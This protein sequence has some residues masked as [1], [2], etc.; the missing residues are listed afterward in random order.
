M[1]ANGNVQGGIQN[2]VALQQT[3]GV[4]NALSIFFSQPAD[5]VA[6]WKIWVRAR[7]SQGMVTVGA[8]ETT[9]PGTSGEP[10]SRMVAVCNCPGATGWAITAFTA[11]AKEQAFV[12]LNSSTDSGGLP[13]GITTVKN[14]NRNANG[15]RRPVTALAIGAAPLNVSGAGSQLWDAAGSIRDATLLAL[16][17]VQFF[18]QPI[19]PVLGDVP[20]AGLPI[21][22]VPATNQIVG[23]GNWVLP[24]GPSGRSIVN[25]LWV[26]VSSTPN[27][28]TPIVG[29]LATSLYANIST[30]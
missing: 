24:L 21:G 9:A 5:S 20:F 18:D 1:S 2:D 4:G 25:Q 30:V 11:G 17:F 3:I 23:G 29:A 15:N 28:F 10:P 8:F 27:T 19:A 6:V 13:P 14:G 7:T 12:Q 22:I 26:A 16:G